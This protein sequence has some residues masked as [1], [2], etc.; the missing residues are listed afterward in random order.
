VAAVA[1]LNPGPEDDLVELLARVPV[2]LV[3]E[4]HYAAGGLGSFVSELVAERGLGCR[5]I[6][7]GVAAMPRGRSGSPGYLHETNRLTPS[8]LVKRVVEAMA[9]A[10]H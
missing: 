1:S 7:A 10:D 6:R 5:V 8:A 4:H 9:L 3:V 2:A